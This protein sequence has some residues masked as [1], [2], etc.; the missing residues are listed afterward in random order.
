MGNQARPARPGTT[1]L[2]PSALTDGGGHIVAKLGH[3]ATESGLAD[4]CLVVLPILPD[5]RPVVG[6]VLRDIDTIAVSL[7]RGAQLHRLV[8][9]ASAKN[10]LYFEPR[11]T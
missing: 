9:T 8:G 6:T 11:P 2:A 1:N 4:I 5:E 10:K 3:R 7:L